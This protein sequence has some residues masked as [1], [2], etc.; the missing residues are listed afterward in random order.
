MKR[1]GTNWSLEYDDG[2][3][4]GVFDEGMPLDAFETEAYPAFEAI[5]GEHREDIVGTADLVRLEDPF[6]DDVLEIWEQAANESAQL[7]N[8]RRAALVADGIKKLSL[9]KKLRVPGAEV[10]T[11]E[12]HQ[13]AIEWAREEP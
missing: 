9:K 12:D 10:G 5:I 1:E 3:V 6:G 13:T 7:P 2:V 8:Y 11:F 4:V